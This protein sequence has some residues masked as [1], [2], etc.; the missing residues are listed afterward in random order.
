MRFSEKY[1][2]AISHA[3]TTLELRFDHINLSTEE[4]LLLLESGLDLEDLLEHADAIAS[5]RVH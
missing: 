1:L 4:V 2:L 5:K 3:L